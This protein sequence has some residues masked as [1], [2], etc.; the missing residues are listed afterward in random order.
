VPSDAPPDAPSHAP[1]DAPA[2]APPDAPTHAFSVSPS[3]IA[4]GSACVGEDSAPVEVTIT[5]EGAM[6]LDALEITLTGEVEAFRLDSSGCMGGVAVGARCAVSVRARPQ[7]DSRLSA[8]LEVSHGAQRIVVAIEAQGSSC[9]PDVEISPSTQEFGTLGVGCPGSA[10]V[11]FTVTSTGTIP[12]GALSVSLAGP[13]AAEFTLVSDGCAAGLAVGGTCPVEV[14]FSPTSI[15]A[16]TASLEVDV[17]GRARSAT[18]TGTAVSPGPIV[19]EPPIHDFGS[20]IVGAES[21]LQHFILRN[22]SC[23]T[24]GPIVVGLAGPDASDFAIDM[25][26]STCGG[27]VLT[28]GA[29]CGVDVLFAPIAIDTRRATLR[30]VAVP[31]GTATAALSGTGL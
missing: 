30:L 29:L 31:G 16:K 11:T 13:S 8:S 19:L 4:F 24:T 2:H 15:G 25:T 27:A 23:V 28:P 14:S 18:L 9:G 26:T 1:P 5:N 6:P 20:R 17:A 22:P 3:S 21:A 12:T 10:V 7:N